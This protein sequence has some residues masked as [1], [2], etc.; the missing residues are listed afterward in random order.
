MRDERTTNILGAVKRGFSIYAMILA[1]IFF[2]IKLLLNTSLVIFDA[3]PEI[4]LLIGLLI[5][6]ITQPKEQFEDERVT[7]GVNQHYNKAFN[8]I[9]PILIGSYVLS[10]ILI[11][12]TNTLVFIT[13]NLFINSFLFLVFV[14]LIFLVRKHNVY[15]NEKFLEGKNYFANIFKMIGYIFVGSIGFAII[16]IILNY[17]IPGTKGSNLGFVLVFLISFVNISVQYFLY[18]IYEYNHYKESIQLSQ[19]KIFIAT[20]NIVLY[21]GIVM[22]LSTFENII[23]IWWLTL[24]IYSSKIDS[25]LISISSNIGLTH[26]IFKSIFLIITAY[27]LKGS[28]IRLKDQ[29]LSFL[30]KLTNTTVIYAIVSVIVAIGIGPL[31]TSLGN[32]DVSTML[33][34]N[35]HIGINY[36]LIAFYIVILI[37]RFI[38]ANNHN[39]PANKLLI[40]PV[41]SSSFMVLFGISSRF[42]LKLFTVPQELLL[43]STIVEFVLSIIVFLIYVYIVKVYSKPYEIVEEDIYDIKYL[44]N[45]ID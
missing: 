14:G 5:T 28:L 41:I 37:Y 1:I 18:S 19:G 38:Y 16:T 26:E 10:L 45:E 31:V 6:I 36:I 29:S 33:I 11:V 30:N 40:I 2:T 21:L 13:P 12:K 32:S 24:M 3:L 15:L 34:Q 43:I 25:S 39:F 23:R 9:F 4:V 27:S 42:A 8:I 22:F 20:R 7:K 17:I 44:K 35:I